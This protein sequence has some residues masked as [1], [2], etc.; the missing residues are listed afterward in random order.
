MGKLLSLI[1][2]LLLTA[3]ALL[4]ISKSLEK[5]PELLV[6]IVDFITKHLDLVALAGLGYGIVC[7]F[8]SL[9][10]GY[11]TIDL[12]IHLISNILIALMALPI[13]FDRVV[14]MISAKYP[15]HVEKSKAIIEELR[16]FSIWIIKQEKAF[17]YTGAAFAVLLFVITFR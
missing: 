11:A 8:L 17:G 4:Y 9:L 12:I 3:F 13:T 7:F 14:S 6:R 10:Q 2:L 15:E 5:K 16:N 1:S